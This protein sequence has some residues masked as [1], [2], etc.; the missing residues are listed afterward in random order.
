MALLL[1]LLIAPELLAFA[2]ALVL[3]IV[4]G[5]FALI[6]SAATWKPDCYGAGKALGAAVRR[7]L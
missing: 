3:A 4:A 1:I 7:L 2:F 6:A 5:P